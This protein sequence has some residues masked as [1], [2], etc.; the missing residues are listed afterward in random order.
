MNSP[1]Q[2]LK[3]FH[4]AQCDYRDHQKSHP[5]PA[6]DDVQHLINLF[7]QA[8]NQ[9]VTTAMTA[10]R[11]RI[12]KERNADRDTIPTQLLL[13]IIDDIIS[14]TQLHPPAAIDL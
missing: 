13:M 5:W 6:I 3:R 2:A 11:G 7:D 8:Y 1:N 10:L 4:Q 9:G 12:V 14:D